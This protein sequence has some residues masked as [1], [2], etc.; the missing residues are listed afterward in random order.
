MYYD[1]GISLTGK[2]VGGMNAAICIHDVQDNST[3]SFL[4]KVRT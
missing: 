3:E 1:I 2:E 4:R